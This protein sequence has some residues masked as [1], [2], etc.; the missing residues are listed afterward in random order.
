MGYWAYTPT[1]PLAP[2]ETF[3]YRVEAPTVPDALRVAWCYPATYPMSLASLGYLLLFARLDKHPLAAPKRFGT[4]QYGQT[5]NVLA[6]AEVWG[7]SFSFELDVFEILKGLE[8]EGLPLYAAERSESDP[9]IFAGGPVPSTN[10]EPYA[11]FFDFF[12]VGEGE[13]LLEAVVELLYHHRTAPKAE[14]LMRLA[15]TLEGVYVPAF[16]EPVYEEGATGALS[17][18]GPVVSGV[19]FPVVKHRVQ[20]VSQAIAVSPILSEA[21]VFGHR[22]LVEVMRGCSHR[23][24]FCLASYST[25]PARAPQLQSLLGVIEQGL[26]FTQNIGLLGVLVADHPE[27]PALCAALAQREGVNVSMGAVRADTVTPAL[28]RVLANSGSHSL[29][30]A[31]ESGSPALRRR[32]NKHLSQEAIFTAA[33]NALA[34]GLKR[35]KLYHMV[36]LPEETEAHLQ[37]SVALVKA[38]KKAYPALKLS[39]GCSSFVPKAWTPFQ[40]QPRMETKVLQ[41]R[42]ETLRKGL[43]N[44]A[45]WKPSSVKWD[46]V[47]ALLSRG[48]RRLAPL[49]VRWAGLGGKL[50][51]LNRALKQLQQE[52]AAPL[53]SVAWYANRQRPEQEVLPWDALN[54][55]VSKAVLWKEGLPPPPINPNLAPPHAKGG[56]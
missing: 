41:Q 4:E 49:L 28:G 14:R 8:A 48:D 16:Y 52:G 42:M 46:D 55:G 54:L 29:T 27:F 1:A 43:L 21:S 24:R 38:L 39:L 15:T 35:L 17:A 44:V 2:E 51:H 5:G 56:V 10:P 22:L 40:W 20:D 23:C 33:E 11:P 3:L 31:I 30:I 18:L 32:I 7:F 47:Q 25:L 19:P 53:P 37:E 26:Q 45:E 13:G 50:G 9:L 12:L 34:V 36:G 6:Q